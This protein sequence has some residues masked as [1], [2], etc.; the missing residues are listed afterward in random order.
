VLLLVDGSY[1]FE[2]ETFEFLNVLQAG[3]YKRPLLS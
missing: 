2:M 1:G 3:A